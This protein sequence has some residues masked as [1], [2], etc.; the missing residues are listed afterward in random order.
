MDMIKLNLIHPEIGEW[1]HCMLSEE[2]FP[3]LGETKVIIPQNLPCQHLKTAPFEADLLGCCSFSSPEKSHL[4]LM[5]LGLQ[6]VLLQEHKQSSSVNLNYDCLCSLAQLECLL[7][8][9]KFE[10]LHRETRLPFENISPFSQ[11]IEA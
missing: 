2:S 1:E 5:Y 11:N 7:W 6:G 3:S 9:R 8:G 4:L 10:G